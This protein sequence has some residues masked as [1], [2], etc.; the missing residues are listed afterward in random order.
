MYTLTCSILRYIPMTHCRMHRQHLT[1]KTKCLH[2]NA[3]VMITIP[4]NSTVI[5]TRESIQKTCLT[6]FLW[7]QQDEYSKDTANNVR[8][9]KMV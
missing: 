6:D 3:I 8:S 4:S 1:D 9:C 7:L 5:I 2:Q